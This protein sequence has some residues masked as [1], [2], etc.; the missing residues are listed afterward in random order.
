MVQQ[1]F[2]SRYPQA[3]PRQNYELPRFHP[4]EIFPGKARIPCRKQQEHPWLH[5]GKR[6]RCRHAHLSPGLG[7]CW[8]CPWR[9]ASSLH[10][11]C[12]PDRHRQQG[13]E[14]PRHFFQQVA[15]PDWHS[16]Q[17]GWSLRNLS[18]FLIDEAACPGN[19]L[20]FMPEQMQW[21]CITR[22]EIPSRYQ[23]AL[24]SIN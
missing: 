1:P 4:E 15:N 23:K 3:L 7:E 2:C 24:E 5:F 17:K 6:H 13:A 20:E 18:V 11:I 16:K 22:K 14:A 19:R 9:E 8:K 10:P 21:L 12:T